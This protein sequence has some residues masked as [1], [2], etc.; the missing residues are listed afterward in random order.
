MD[1]LKA[2]LLGRSVPGRRLK[3]RT[4]HSQYRGVT[5]S[6]NMW[7]ACLVLKGRKLHLGAFRFESDAAIC[8]NY[9]VAHL[10]LDR[11]LNQITEFNHDLKG[12]DCNA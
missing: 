11:P 8:W 6:R 9:H 3:K 4:Y 1:E 12:Q 7:Q 5:K 10:G 2:K